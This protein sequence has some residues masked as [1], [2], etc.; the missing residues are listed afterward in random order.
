[1]ATRINSCLQGVQACFTL[2]LLSCC[3]PRQ[4]GGHPE[5]GIMPLGTLPAHALL[6]LQAM[7][8]LRPCCRPGQGGGHPGGQHLQQPAVA[9]GRGQAA[10]VEHRS[11]GVVSV[12][13]STV[14]L[15][16]GLPVGANLHE[17]P[18]GFGACHPMCPTSPAGRPLK[19]REAAL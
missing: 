5:A 7:P 10:G 4:G 15:N 6:D 8:F 13:R 19:A 11:W 17:Q 18:Q 12:S 3:R 1:V 14:R 9:H 16:R 2:S